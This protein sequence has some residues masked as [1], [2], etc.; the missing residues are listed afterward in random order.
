MSR[1]Q[2]LTLLAGALCVAACGRS[3]LL[4]VNEV[5]DAEADAGADARAGVD[6]GEREGAGADARVDAGADADAGGDAYAD[7]DAG[8]PPVVVLFGGVDQASTLY[9]DTWEWDGSSWSQK[10]STGPAARR[11]HAMAALGGKVLL[12]GGRTATTFFADTWEWDG[13][14]WTDRTPTSG[15]SPSAR[16]YHCMASMSDRI[17]LYGGHVV[18]DGGSEFGFVDTWEWNGTAWTQVGNG[19]SG[20]NPGARSNAA[21]ASSNNTQPSIFGGFDDVS[22]TLSDTWNWNVSV[23]WLSTGGVTALHPPARLDHAMAATVGILVTMY[24]GFDGTSKYLADTWTWNSKQWN[25]LM[26]A[27][28][29]PRAGHSMAQRG[30][31]HTVLFGGSDG[32]HS[33]ADTWEWDG[34]MWARRATTGPP[35]RQF[36]AMSTR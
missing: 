28:P 21:M 22:K 2:A 33:L 23:G 16:A 6:A 34:A 5:V 9:G 27:G 7:A 29:G 26:V 12:F 17:L 13:H 36:G 32:T 3:Y 15:P 8:P 19:A 1:R 24:G 31:S 18:G 20:P 14:T 30:D 10:S 25:Q 4:D 35:A 11:G